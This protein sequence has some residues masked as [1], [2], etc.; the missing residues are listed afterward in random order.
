MQTRAYKGR[1]PR[2]RSVSLSTRPSSLS[3]RFLAA[4]AATNATMSS[5]ATYRS[6]R[7]RWRRGFSNRS[8]AGES[9]ELVT[10]DS[11]FRS[12]RDAN[13]GLRQ[14]ER[15]NFNESGFQ[16][17]SFNPRQ[18][19]PR[20]QPFRRPPPFNPN[21]PFRQSPAFNPNQ[22]FQQP[23]PFNPNQRFRQ[24]PAFNPNQPFNQ[25]HRFQ[26]PQQFQPR[27]TRPLDY[28]NWEYSEAGPSSHC[29][30][31]TVL[32]YNI[33]ADYLA[34]NQRSRLYFHIP[35]H[36]LDWEWRKRNII[37]ELGLW[38][39]DVMCFQE[40]DR[41]GDLEEELKLRGYTGIWKMRT[42]DPVDGCAI[43][44]RA[45][46]FKLL[47]EECIEFNKLGLRD[48]VAQIC[49]LESINQNYSGSTSALPASSTGSNKVVICNIHVLYNPRRG[50]I[51]LG[52]VRALLDKAHAVSK[53]WNDAPIVICGDFNC[54][55]KSPLYNFISEQK[56]DLSGLDRDKVSGQASAEIRAPR[57]FSPNPRVQLTDNSVQGLTMNDVRE[58]G[59]K[60]SDSLLEIQKQT[61]P[62]S[63]VGNVASMDNLSQ[64][65]C[66]NTVLHVDKSCTNGQHENDTRAPSDEMIKET[67]Q[68]K[69]GGFENETEPTAYDPVDDS[70]ENQ[71]ISLSEGEAVVD[72]VNGGIW[73]STPPAASLHEE[74]YSSDMIERRQGERITVISNPVHQFFSEHSQPGVDDEK[75]TPS[76]P[77]EVNISDA[78]TSFDIVLDKQ[79]ENLTLDEPDEDTEE[80]GNLGEDCSTFLS[81]LN[82]TEETFP[83]DFGQSV[84]SDQILDDFSPSIEPEPFEMEISAYDPSVWTPMEIETATG[85]ADCTH[86]EHPLKLRSTYT[87]VEDRSGTKDSNGE[88]LVTSYNRC[89]LGTVD[90]IW[91]SEGLKTIRALAPIPKQAMQWTPGFPTKKWGSDHIALAT[92]LAFTKD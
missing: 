43:F 63:N 23:P 2:A 58:V 74:T 12:V 47:H 77:Y 44:W 67:Q 46:R 41:F 13:L 78:S 42:G 9:G 49:V 89:F 55:P 54:T 76:T 68:E 35:R 91:R 72:Q 53:I 10:G 28:R 65:Q 19:F 22:P 17:Q 66:I 90:Y 34:V 64:A 11:H 30:R 36:M 50:E 85:N 80:N 16:P 32:S 3:L 73:E 26:Q 4:A 56:L 79:L 29:E 60:D 92:E 5:R 87:E 14:G 51:K 24:P 20:N 39:A 86:L 40:V 61:Y 6:S 70:K 8:D 57:Q 83:S 18:P 31:F 75:D 27:P 7:N 45:S 84:R 71:S 21:Q 82:K 33:L 52:Q 81:E 15:R 38:S 69:V 62:D 59:A 1:D 88:P 25:N 37:F 48:N